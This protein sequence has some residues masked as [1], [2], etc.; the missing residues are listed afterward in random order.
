MKKG[1]KVKICALTT[2]QKTMDWFVVDS[3]RNLSNNGYGVTLVCNMD[4][5]FIVQNSDFA[6]CVDLKM[7]RGINLKNSVASIRALIKL[8]KREK[9]DIIYYVTPNVSLCASIAGVL[10]GVK[11]RVYSQCGLRYVS[12]TGA[13]RRIFKG[14]EKITCMLSTYIRAQSPMNMEFAVKEGLCK[15]DKIS[16]V[17]IGGTIGVD[18]TLCDAFDKSK[19]R[20]EIKKQYNI[21]QDAFVFGYVGRI[22][23]DKGIYELLS[24]FEKLETDNTYLMLIGMMDSMDL[25]TRQLVERAKENPKIIFTGDIPKDKVYEYMSA[26]DVMV[27]PTYREGFGKVL[28]EAM[29]MSIPIITTNVPGPCEVI[30]HGKSGVLVEA[31]DI[32]DLAEKMLYV[33]NNPE[34]RQNL[35]EIGRKRA[36]TYFDRPIM[37]RNI[38]CDMNKIVGISEVEQ[39]EVNALNGQS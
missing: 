14:L 17:G 20:E 18:L 36:E 27:H 34:L 6:W 33:Y 26:F 16:V 21:P 37:L 35:S 7:T 31:Y 39:S 3:M 12:F 28:Q 24:A 2:V 13:K 4:E 23:T 29:G 9:F 32:E 10:A 15:R 38:L 25:K 22:N 11:L 5:E 1:E 8:F 19:K 30:E